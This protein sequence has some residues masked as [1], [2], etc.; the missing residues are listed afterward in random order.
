MESQDNLGL[1]GVATVVDGAVH[2]RVERALND[3]P[4]PRNPVRRGVL[5]LR[6]GRRLRPRLAYE[7]ERRGQQVPAFADLGYRRPR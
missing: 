6:A 5:M 3:F 1:A 4:V 2:V 7:A